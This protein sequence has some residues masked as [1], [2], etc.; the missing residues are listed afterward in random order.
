[1]FEHH[2]GVGAFGNGCAG[3]DLERGAGL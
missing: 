3:H 2:D 1:V